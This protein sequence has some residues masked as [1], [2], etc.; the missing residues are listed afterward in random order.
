MQTVQM[1]HSTYWRDQTR[2]STLRREDPSI[3]MNLCPKCEIRP[4]QR[5]GQCKNCR[6]RG[7]RRIFTWTA[8]LDQSLIDAYQTAATVKQLHVSLK[9]VIQQTGFTRQV[10]LKRAQKLGI[11][12]QHRRWS[13]I[14]KQYLLDHAG[15]MTAFEMARVLHRGVDTTHVM[16]QKLHRSA[17][18]SYGYTRKDVRELLGVSE[19]KVNY[20]I[21]RGWLYFDANG[22]MSETRVRTFLIRHPDEYSL[23][24][25]DEYW[26]KSLLFPKAVGNQVRRQIGTKEAA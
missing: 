2:H 1:G 13:E 11:A 6:C 16:L 21:E 14:E 3:A 19:K 4:A 25:V 8:A 20:W 7:M 22:R 10:V 12:S 23:R 26:F 5:D 9:R 15:D 17:R 24:R 18:L